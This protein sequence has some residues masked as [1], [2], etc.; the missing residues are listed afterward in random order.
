[1]KAT[2]SSTLETL[3]VTRLERR[4]GDAVTRGSRRSICA[5]LRQ[6][7]DL[8]VRRHS[9]PSRDFSRLSSTQSEPSRRS[10]LSTDSCEQLADDEFGC[11][12]DVVLVSLDADELVEIL[13]EAGLDEFGSKVL[14][15]KG[16]RELV[17]SVWGEAF[18]DVS[19]WNSELGQREPEIEEVA[20]LRALK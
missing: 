16:C 9:A 4:I 10:F 19:G 12:V 5:P 3:F 15:G 11:G 1:M 2:A 20:A 8:H 18:D 14:F 7:H 17:R 6:R 13:P